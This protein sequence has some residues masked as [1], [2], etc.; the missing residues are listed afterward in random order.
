MQEQEKRMKEMIDW[1]LG[2]DGEWIWS[3]REYV[4]VDG[5][6]RMEWMQASEW[7]GMVGARAH[8]RISPPG[9]EGALH[10]SFSAILPRY[11]PY[12][13]QLNTSSIY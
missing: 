13:V 6:L 7:R 1:D 11:L 9:E 5:G 12:Y 8:A 4:G 10:E 3:A 2:C